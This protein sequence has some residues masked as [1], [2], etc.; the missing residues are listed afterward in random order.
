VIIRILVSLVPLWR[1]K[2][3]L[4]C[5]L[6]GFKIHPSAYIGFSYIFPKYLVMAKESRI[7]HGNVCKGLSSL[8]MGRL[9]SI[10]QLNWITGFPVNTGSRHFATQQ[11]RDPKL[12][13][14]KH[15][16]IT[17]RHLIDCT[18]SVFIDEFAIVAGYGSQLLTHS[19]DPWQ[20]MQ[21][22]SPVLIGKR[23]FIGTRAIIL[24]GCNVAPRIIVGAGSIVASS[25]RDSLCLYAGSPARFIKHL[26]SDLKFFTRDKGYVY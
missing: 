16:A 3:F 9:S 14:A 2:R 24:P 23:S 15:A 7:G 13:I 5:R 11:D 19:I 18:S 21:T 20:S 17:S 25:L 8:K 4:L 12:V 10:G 26:P 1:L 22:S 6:Y